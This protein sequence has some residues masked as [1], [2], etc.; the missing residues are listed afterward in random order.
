MKPITKINLGRKWVILLIVKY[1]IS[2]SKAVR[3]GTHTRQEPG[4]RYC[5][6]GHREVCCSLSFSGCF[7]VES[8]IINP[9]MALP[10]TGWALPHQSQNMKISYSL[11]YSLIF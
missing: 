11:A 4:G 6:R 1:N 10:I 5:C 7:L 3:M 9:G 8:R 2:L